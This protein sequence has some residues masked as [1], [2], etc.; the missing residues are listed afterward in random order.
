MP[1]CELSLTDLY[2]HILYFILFSFKIIILF[3][4]NIRDTK[5]GQ[6]MKDI[7]ISEKS[8]FTHPIDTVYRHKKLQRLQNWLI[9]KSQSEIFSMTFFSVCDFS[10]PLRS[11]TIQHHPHMMSISGSMAGE[12]KPDWHDDYVCTTV[13]LY[14]L[15]VSQITTTQTYSSPLGAMWT[16]AWTPPAMTVMQLF[17]GGSL[18]QILL[19]RFKAEMRAKHLCRA[20]QTSLAHNVCE[21]TERRKETHIVA[22]RQNVHL[23]NLSDEEP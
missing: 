16:C 14:N 5:L 2:F 11:L 13:C 15:C 21:L 22:F 18:P 4:F 10:L 23:Q 9:K 20:L 17:R 7:I 3:N 8:F 6:I 1:N 19:R 12:N